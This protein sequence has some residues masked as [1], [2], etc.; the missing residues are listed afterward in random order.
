[1][2][3]PLLLAEYETSTRKDFARNAFENLSPAMSWG[4]RA[5]VSPRSIMARAL[6]P[7]RRAYDNQDAR[8]RRHHAARRCQRHVTPV[9]LLNGVFGQGVHIDRRGLRRAGRY[10]PTTWFK[11]VSPKPVEPSI[12]VALERCREGSPD[13]LDLPRPQETRSRRR[14]LVDGQVRA[15]GQPESQG[16]R[17]LPA[18]PA[19]SMNSRKSMPRWAEAILLAHESGRTSNVA[20]L[21][22]WERPR[23]AR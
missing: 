21:S 6:Q 11:A 20:R 5:T 15:H 2:A 3:T 7:D 23:G 13:R 22:L 18:H 16:S 4:D 1:M 8:A 14:K 17:S 9:L 19:L 10:G 12:D